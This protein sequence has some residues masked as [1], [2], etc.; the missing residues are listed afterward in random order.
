MAP[1]K[2]LIAFDF[3]GTLNTRKD[4]R[5]GEETFKTLHQLSKLGIKFVI[6]TAA[7]LGWMPSVFASAQRRKIDDIF[8]LDPKHAARPG[9]WSSQSIEGKGGKIMPDNPDDETVYISG[10]IITGSGGYNK[11]MYLS[12]FIAK[13]G[14][15]YD[16]VVFL[17]DASLNC[18]DMYESL[19]NMLLAKKKELGE[20]VNIHTIFVPRLAEAYG[21]PGQEENEIKIQEILKKQKTFSLK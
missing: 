17:D 12:E 4:L 19:R 9:L 6:V 14:G 5:G 20:K 11:P 2:I 8:S 15:D 10:N 1:E 21:E 7:K 13:T 16:T 18:I 3:D